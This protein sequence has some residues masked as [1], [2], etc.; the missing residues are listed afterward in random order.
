MRRRRNPFQAGTP[1]PPTEYGGTD[2]PTATHVI[3]GRVG[4]G[5]RIDLDLR[6]HR[7]LGGEPDELHAVQAGQIGH[8]AN[9][10][11]VPED[12]VGK[13]WDVAH[14]DPGADDGPAGRERRQ[15][16]GHQLTDGANDRGVQVPRLQVADRSGPDG[17]QRARQILF[18]GIALAGERTPAL[19][20]GDLTDQVR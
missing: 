18:L 7:Y 3:D 13:G 11:L 20:H 5:E 19:M 9:G 16:L 8:G 1:R 4:F 14:V 17:S 6:P 15:R 10:V 12:L 2:N